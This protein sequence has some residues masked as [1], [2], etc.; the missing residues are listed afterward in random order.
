MEEFFHLRRARDR[1]N[2][3]KIHAKSQQEKKIMEPPKKKL[4]TCSSAT[5]TEEKR[6][7]PGDL[8]D[9][10]PNLEVLA[11]CF[12]VSNGLELPSLL[13]LA[14]DG[15]WR[16]FQKPHSGPPQLLVPV[17]LRDRL[18]YLVWVCSVTNTRNNDNNS[19][20]IRVVGDKNVRIEAHQK[21]GSGVPSRK[22]GIKWTI[23]YRNDIHPTLLSRSWTFICTP[24]HVCV[25]KKSKC[26]K[27]PSE[28]QHGVL[29]IPKRSKPIAYSSSKRKCVAIR[30]RVYPEKEERNPLFKAVL[31]FLW[32]QRICR[33]DGVWETDLFMEVFLQWGN[34]RNEA[35][36]IIL[37]M[38]RLGLLRE[39]EERPGHVLGPQ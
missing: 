30:R 26:P 13:Y 15:A 24:T 10:R 7:K 22:T 31:D 23:R 37:E 35:D 1:Q 17:E 16:E 6:K 3:K 36:L 38:K 28:D 32:N 27:V 39:A 25:V 12:R 11:S 2:R 19:V 14:C 33:P 8:D 4:R 34:T 9:Y 29:L 18:T 20:S 21:F 5:A